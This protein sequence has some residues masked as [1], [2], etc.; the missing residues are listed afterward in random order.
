MH[1][2]AMN[3]CSCSMY[4]PWLK[5]R[6]KASFYPHLWKYQPLLLAL[7]VYTITV[8]HVRADVLITQQGTDWHD[9]INTDLI[10]NALAKG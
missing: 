2:V 5:S 3:E 6:G 10:Q 8:D 9:E 7:I 1:H 4:V